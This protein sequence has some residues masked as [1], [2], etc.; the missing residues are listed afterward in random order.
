[1]AKPIEIV[2]RVCENC[3]DYAPAASY[4]EVWKGTCVRMGVKPHS[5]PA[6]DRA[7]GWDHV[8]Y[9]EGCWVGPQ[10]GCIHWKEK[11]NG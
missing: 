6:L 5:T 8:G 3:V 4:M 2:P 11:K 10:F 1:M 9:S 7:F